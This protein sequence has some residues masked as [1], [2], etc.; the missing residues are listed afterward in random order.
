MCKAGLDVDPK[1]SYPAGNEHG[2]AGWDVAVKY[3]DLADLAKLLSGGLA[4]APE[5]CTKWFGCNPVPIQPGEVWRLAI[6]AHG[7]QGGVIA[8][9]GK[10]HPPFLTAKTVAA[11]HGDLHT[12][13][14]ATR[15]GSTIILMGC[16]AGQGELGT[17]LLMELS[18]VWPG[19]QVVGFTTAGY[20]H[21]GAMKK[22]GES[23]V[24]PGMRDTDVTAYLFADPPKLDKLWSD[25]V[26]MPW[27]SETSEHAKVV[28]DGKVLR[29]PKGECIEIPP[30][31]K[32]PAPRKARAASTHSA[33]P[34]APKVAK[35]SPGAI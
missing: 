4:A 1:L 25:F 7:D 3:Q 6:M 11:R 32:K 27:A 35:L 14:L 34:L 33:D 18:T 31:K 22:R 10:D 9:D 24:Y 15:R 29:C 17:R 23:C 30:A 19:R 12:I 21:P 16:L 26:K 28:L 13:G 20:G 5:T 2:Q 8:V